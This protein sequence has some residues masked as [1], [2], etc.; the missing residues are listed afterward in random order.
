MIATRTHYIPCTEAEAVK[1]LHAAAAERFVCTF[2]LGSGE[3]IWQEGEPLPRAI[4]LLGLMRG[5]GLSG[6]DGE[7]I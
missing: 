4:E 1:L 7:G 2:A 3:L 5:V 6:I